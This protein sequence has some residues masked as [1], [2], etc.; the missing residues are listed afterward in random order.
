M[1]ACLKATASEAH[2]FVITADQRGSR[3]SDDLVPRALEIVRAAAPDAPVLGPER[4]IGDEI[5]VAVADAD[6]AL[7][8]ILALSRS[9]RWSI[10]LGIGDVEEPY[11]ASIRAARGSAFI[12]ARDAVGDAKRAPGRLSIAPDA[13]PHASD[14][15]ALIRL[16]ID[17]RDRRTDEGWEVYDLLAQGMTQRDAAQALGVT[18]AA[19][20]LRARAAGLRIEE[21][22]LPAL[23]RA[24]SAAGNAPTP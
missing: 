11:P 18:A 3:I 19:V 21:G 20:S 13:S 7:A 4:T 16:L 8:I 15:Q 17:V 5:Q 23:V 22:A 10:G 6:A 24:L 9:Q 14:A 1:Y 12:R 2:V